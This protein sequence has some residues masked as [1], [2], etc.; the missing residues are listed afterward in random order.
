MIALFT[1]CTK[2]Y[3]QSYTFGFSKFE[4][5]ASLLLKKNTPYGQTTFENTLNKYN[6]TTDL[7]S[8]LDFLVS[9]QLNKKIKLYS[10]IGFAGNGFSAEIE[11][12]DPKYKINFSAELGITS[13]KIPIRVGYII[14]KRFE[15][16]GGLSINFNEN[17]SV[18]Y[19]TII[20]VKQPI[21][22]LSAIISLW[23]ITFLCLILY[24]GV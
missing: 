23:L 20:K 6:L 5:A 18:F 21:L 14:N 13:L 19:Q 11:L 16:I 4:I 1:F 3:C 24:Q 15:L 17:S 10:G 8:Q 2:G 22:L 9:Y 7:S 12:D